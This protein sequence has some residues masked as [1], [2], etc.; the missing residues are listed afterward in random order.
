MAVLLALLDGGEDDAT[1]AAWV[2]LRARAR[3]RACENGIEQRGS[4]WRVWAAREIASE[5]EPLVDF[6]GSGREPPAVL[7]LDRAHGDHDPADRARGDWSSRRLFDGTA[8]AS[9][10]VDASGRRVELTRDVMGQRALV[11]ATTPRGFVVASGEDILCAHPDVPADLDLGWFAALIAGVSPELDASVYRAIRVL[12]AGA[13]LTRLDGKLA[14]QLEGL[15]VD[16][17][18]AGLTDPEVVERFRGHVDRAVSRSLRGV[19]RP[20]ILLSGGVDSALVAE[21]VARQWGGRTRPLAVVYGFDQWPA[22]DERELA[23][24]TADRL[25]FEL[26]AF[27]ADGLVPMRAELARPVCPDTALATPYREIKEFAYQVAVASGCDAVISGNFGDH[28]YAHPARWMA[29]ALQRGRFDVIGAAMS[30]SGLGGLLR[31]PGVRILARSWRLTTPPQPAGLRRL[32]D[33]WREK[34]A[35]ARLERLSALAAW[36]RP[37]QAALCLDAHAAFDA[38]GEQWFASRHGLAFRQPLRDPDLTRFMLSLPAIHSTRGEVTKW[39]ARTALRDRLPAAVVDRPKGSDLTPFAE[40]ADHSERQSLTAREAQVRPLLSQL[41]SEEGHGDLERGELRW[42]FA[43]VAQWIEASISQ[44]HVEPRFVAPVGGAT[45][46][47][48]GAP[49]KTAST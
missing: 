12:P 14:M 8:C 11:Y 13:M 47:A 41:L 21:S 32:R 27:V 22:I 34:L 24:Q 37:T 26:R 38:H 35:Q 18:V 6:G 42:L 9:I 39:V 23:R 43:S 17:S 33:T 16:R 48:A 31:D 45:K 4:G 44:P 7:L 20:A 40:A 30:R 2:A 46:G 10:R 1:E 25:G 5:P 3:A 15:T 36:P 28:L 49:R 19:E 29:D